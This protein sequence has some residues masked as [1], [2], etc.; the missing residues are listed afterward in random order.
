MGAILSKIIGA[1]FK[2]PLTRLITTQGAGHFAVAYNIYIVLLNI[3]STGLPI[4][5]SR[6]ISQA[7]TL[8]DRRRTQMLHRTSLLLFLGIG[9]V[10]GG[11]ML[12]FAPQIADWMRDP[13]AVYAI[14]A[15]APA[16]LFVCVSSA[17]RGYFQGQQYMTPT[18]VAQVLE[19]F[20]KLFLG[21]L[22]AFLALR[23]GWSYP[24]AAG[25]SILGVTVGAM[26]G[27]LYFYLRYRRF[28]AVRESRSIPKG[29]T[30]PSWAAAREILRLAIPI[31][32][33]ATGFQIINVLCS[34][35]ILGRLQDSLLLPLEQASSLLGI[36]TN[37]QTLYLL[38]SA[39]AQ[40]LA[41]S[42]V[43]AITEA[44][45][46]GQRTECQKKTESAIRVVGLIAIPCGVGLCVL[47]APIQ[48]LLYGY[49]AAALAIAGPVLRVLGLSSIL[50]CF[51]LVTNAVLQAHGKVYIS[52]YTTVI[53]GLVC[54]ISTY[55]L[56]G[57]PELQIYGAALGTAVYGL[58]AVAINIAAIKRL[59]QP[60]GFLAQL[61]KTAG[62]ALV[63]ALGAGG[64]YALTHQVLLA[65]LTA[66]ILYAAMV[67]GMKVLTWYDCCLFSKGEKIARMLHITNPNPQEDDVS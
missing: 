51:V 2:I 45:S 3:S 36:Y 17:F 23:A 35:V 4:A 52:V 5:V 7:H 1:L 58:I 54:L 29:E 48:G 10:T 16:V 31:T 59:P 37:A 63:M 13:D 62:A 20:S 53:G 25:A 42:I 11:A 50:Y 61:Y 57:R 47:S 41:V 8:Q 27:S 43:P 67:Y 38:P 9:L 33:G 19:A 28:P 49:D 55:I 14:A 39:L 21:L 56:V 40:P 12:A 32:L 66:G 18:A 34:K 30:A 22:G 46:L 64:S 44:I 60:P 6:L 24:M 15:L 65:V 26:L